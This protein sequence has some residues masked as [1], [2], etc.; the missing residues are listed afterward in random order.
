VQ[1]LTSSIQIDLGGIGKGFAVDRMAE[2]LREWSIDIALISG[3]YSSVLALD[4]PPDTK[5]WPVTF[6]NPDNSEAKLALLYLQGRA[7]GASG[8]QKG[9]HII[10]T[11]SGRPAETKIAVWSLAPDAATADALS[12]AFMV[13]SPDEIK[14]YCSS[15]LDVQ[16]M[17]ILQGEKKELQRGQ[18]LR[19][20]RWEEDGV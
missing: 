7:V 11:R 20:G 2:L 3:G 13:M 18:I 6:S 12:T 19:F 1:L 8:L 15:H 10:D 16:A 4:A 14:K 17:V 9:W 5:G